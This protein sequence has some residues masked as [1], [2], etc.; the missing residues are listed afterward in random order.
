MF[1][2]H[3]RVQR[4]KEQYPQGTRIR[5]IGMDDPYAPIPPGTEG[6]VNLVDDI[7]TLHCSFDNGRTLGVIPGEDQFSVISR[8][9]QS[10]LSENETEQFGM[11]MN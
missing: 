3:K 10:E 5:L 11:R 2:D 8:P 4:M 7:G 1:I 6:T 9:E